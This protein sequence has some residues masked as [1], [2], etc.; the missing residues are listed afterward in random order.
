MPLLLLLLGCLATRQP[1]AAEETAVTLQAGDSVLFIGNS[2][3]GSE[4]G[5]QNHFRRTCAVA[6]LALGIETFWT[7][8]YGANGLADMLTDQVTDRLR[9]GQDRFVVL[10]SGE[11]AALRKA[12]E[13]GQQA[14]RSMVVLMA[15]PEQYRDLAV[16]RDQ[17]ASIV[18]DVKQVA[19]AT[20][21]A[22]VPSAWLYYDLMAAPPDFPGLRP[23]WLFVP[24]STVQNDLGT[25][26]NVAA[27]YAV[28]TGRSPV[29][30]PCWEP[31][32]KELV[33]AIEAR[34]WQL[35]QDWQAGR[36]ELRRLPANQ[37]GD[38]PKPVPVGAD[39]AWP[40][41]IQDGNRVFYVGNS[42]IGTEGGLDNH[43]ARTL[44]QITPAVP[45]TT[46]SRIFWGQPLDRMATDEVMREI[47]TGHH[48]VVVVT[49]GSVEK[50]DQF[51]AAI[52]QAGSKMVIH[53]T[54]GRNPTINQGGM[55]GFR[56]DT[57][58]IANAMKAYEQ[59][60]GVP[61]APCGLVFYD[62]L[63]DPPK[64]PGLRTD[65]TFMP[66]NIHQ[67]QLGSMINV[68]THY[69]TL[70]GRSPVGLPDW[71]PYPPGLI[72]AVQ[73]RAW[74]VVQA[75]QRGEVVIKPLA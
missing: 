36:I 53:M 11:P 54:W 3:I 56:A 7:N 10:Q 21:A 64:V 5:L 30:L 18:A 14:G 47:V 65:F 23:D 38:L 74:Q 33:E 57:E 63:A 4:G 61:V 29:G 19:E 72:R 70:C 17:T 1:S 45:I 27:T 6:E 66:E 41:I 75:W 13:F 26:V 39:G 62:L 37:P 20:G 49:S 35:V 52:D 46:D 69:A 58:R 31:F 43:F 71:D 73:E 34:V 15:W 9:N 60:T 25:L 22:V 68:A 59:R 2:R 67:G 12:V 42:F 24:G 40:P 8:A 16:Y 48:D 51:R 32:P 44:R 28:T 50:L 55:A